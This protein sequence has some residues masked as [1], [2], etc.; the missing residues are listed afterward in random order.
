MAKNKLNEGLT[1]FQS[2]ADQ[3]SMIGPRGQL[4]RW[5]AQ[6]FATTAVPN[7]PTD[8]SQEGDLPRFPLQGDA[9]VSRQGITPPGIGQSFKAFPQ[10]TQLEQNRRRRYA[11]FENMDVYPEITTAFDIYADDSTQKDDLGMKW[12]VKHPDKVIVDE[13]NKLFETIK[14]DRV[15]WDIV[16]NMVK[17]GDNFIEN[18]LDV[19][20]PK[21]GIQRI[22]IL[23]PNFILRIESEEGIL[24]SFLQEI[25]P[26]ENYGGGAAASDQYQEKQ[27]IGLD[28]NQIVHFRLFT[29]EYAY[30]PYGKSVAAAAIA[31]YRSL[32]L[33]ED[34]MLIYRISRAPERRVFYV[35]VGSMPT[36]KAEAYIEKL[37]DKFKKERFYNPQQGT[38]DARFNPLSVDEDFYVPVKNND[39]GTRIETLPGAANLGEVDD[40]KYFRDKLLA[41]LK[42]PKDYIVEKDQSPERKANLSQ[43]D[44]KFA[45]TVGRVQE[46][47]ELGLEELA[48][49][50]LQL[51]GY[52]VALIRR[53][54]INLSSPSDLFEKRRLDLE[55]QRARA[56]QAKLGLGMFPKEMI[57]KEVWNLTD[58]E[59]EELKRK[60]E[61]EMQEEAELQM[62]MGIVPGQEPGMA[63]A[64]PPPGGDPNAQIA[65]PDL[66]VEAG[67]QEP[68][69]NRTPTRVTE[70]LD[71][72]NALMTDYELVGSKKAKIL[73]RILE[74][75]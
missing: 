63:G 64:A 74:R 8:P 66:D 35:N 65:G 40:V 52:P 2:P 36:S 68:N 46:A 9:P 1:S 38:I 12:K 26:K 11:N 62:E 24:H 17:F 45:R 44:V 48:K 19:A 3:S 4:A 10:L 15:L 42:V 27:Y 20:H 50:H 56:V 60:L 71:C 72:L 28:K 55:E 73:Q 58:R 39:K 21:K 16:R 33:M 5:Y 14:L 61:E 23:N 53:V 25:P 70:G 32:R 43:L 37:K 34:A 31:I 54:R 47:A 41:L 6:F 67:G 29:S 7:I 13:V 22:K 49:R 57:Y 59:I 69:E 51:K 75:K 30:Y 18:V